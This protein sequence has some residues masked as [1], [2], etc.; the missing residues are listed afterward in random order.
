MGII[1]SRILE[2]PQRACVRSVAGVAKPVVSKPSLVDPVLAITPTW[3]LTEGAVCHDA[4]T[5]FR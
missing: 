4:A 2:K 1:L 5:I 3:P